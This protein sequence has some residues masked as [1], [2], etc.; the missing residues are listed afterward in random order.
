MFRY[1]GKHGFYK[2]PQKSKY[3]NSKFSVKPMRTWLE[4]QKYVASLDLLDIISY[5]LVFVGKHIGNSSSCSIKN[6][7]KLRGLQ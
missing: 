5:N 7:Q 1:L 4:C 2:V 6:C 3:V